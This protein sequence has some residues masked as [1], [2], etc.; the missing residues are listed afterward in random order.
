MLLKV[1]DEELLKYIS[2]FIE[3]ED[4]LNKI[5]S[6]RKIDIIKGFSGVGVH[7]KL[8]FI[9]YI[10]IFHIKYFFIFIFKF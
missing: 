4:F 1:T 6:H 2:D 7:S 8:I 3:K 10:S 9:N 5:K